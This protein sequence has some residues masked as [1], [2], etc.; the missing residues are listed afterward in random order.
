MNRWLLGLQSRTELMRVAFVA[1]AERQRLTQE[2]AALK[3]RLRQARGDIERLW[4]ERDVLLHAVPDR[5]AA[6][7]RVRDAHTLAA[8]DPDGD[9]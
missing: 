2:N 4:R 1:S 8:L 5:R 7:D 3:V 6:L 9:A